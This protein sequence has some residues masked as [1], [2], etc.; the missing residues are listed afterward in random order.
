VQAWR[1]R[2]DARAVELE[3][4][5]WSREL[6]ERPASIKGGRAWDRAV[7]Q[8]VEYRQRWKVADAERALGPEPHGKDASLEQ[9]QARRHADR[10]VGRLRDL[11]GDRDHRPER[12]EA[13]CRSHHRADRGRP[14]DRDHDLGHE[15]AV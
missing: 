4:P 3:R 1:K 14:R 9:R 15:R 7:G 2:A 13:T 6:G 10:A 11:A 8:A 12:Q 5:G